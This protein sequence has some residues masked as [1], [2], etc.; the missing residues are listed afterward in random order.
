MSKDYSLKS[1]GG[2]NEA[3]KPLGLRG[4]GEVD[5]Q[6]GAG[7]VDEQ[8]GAGEI[9]ELADLGAGSSPSGLFALPKIQRDR[10]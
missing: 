5:E 7:E 2:M 1:K 8:T 6:T 4:A 9:D 3:C 10:T